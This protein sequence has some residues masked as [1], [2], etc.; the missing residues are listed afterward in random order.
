MQPGT[1]L[2]WRFPARG[3]TNHVTVLML[4]AKDSHPRSLQF[5]TNTRAS[6]VAIFLCSGIRLAAQTSL[7][8][9][10]PLETARHLADEHRWQDIVALLGSPAPRS[11]D[12]NL[13]YGTALARL[14][15]WPEAEDAFQAGFRIAPG[16][17]RFP[18]EL[19][20]TAFRQRHYSVAARRLRQAIRLA[21]DDPYANNFLG[22]VYFLE[23]N[24]E[25]ALKYWN[26]V[27]KP[28][29]VEVREDPLPRVSPALL[30]R[31]FAFS[32]AA[33]LGL[34][35]LHATDARIRALEIFPRYQFDLRARGDDK[36]DVLFRAQERNGLGSTRWEALFLFLRGLPF[37]SVDPEYFNLHR[38]AINFVSQFRWDAQKRRIYA[39]FSSPFEHSGNTRYELITDLRS[40]NWA[41]LHSFAGPSPLLGSL[42]LRREAVEFCLS[43]QPTGELRWSAGAE[44]SH[45]D[46]RSIIPGTALTPELLR[47]G[48][49]LKQQAQLSATLYRLPE[50][51]FTVEAEA[52]SQAA[53]LWSLSQASFE[54]LQGSAGWH[55]FP[56]AEGNDYETRQQFRTG[57]TF[58]SVPFDEL[59][60]LGLERDNNLPMRAHI[61]TRD[62]HKGSAPLGRN[63]FLA[64]WETDKNVYSNGIVAVKVGPFLDTG[65]IGDPLR[66]LGSHEWLCDI[67]A[68][69]KLR[70]F[71]SG[72]VFSYGKDLRSGNNAF[73]V[74]LLK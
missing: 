65:T 11:A 72:V 21:P 29:I 19:A 40:E 46:F 3:R 68:Q 36:F 55:W 39:Q 62:G 53:R 28:A 71:G 69:A 25:A 27:G 30:D 9:I 35:E 32:P 56:R 1:G 42:N 64:T 18:I 48:Y 47:K 66:A 16:D 12:M 24:L 74:S 38:Q 67:G 45:R 44:I 50:R 7:A 14:E 15:R 37:S 51:R 2:C 60:M 23:G 43:S 34:P 63:Y 33:T 5:L 8:A 41:L 57:K 20:G 58:G 59:F 17:P 26:R 49:Q 6:L 31:A 22:T 61:G 4:K 73:Y 10:P 70:V 13:L 54:K 52:S